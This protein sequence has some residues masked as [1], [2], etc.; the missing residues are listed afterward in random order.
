MD[1]TLAKY[2]ELLVA[3]KWAGYASLT[4][5]DY[6]KGE[7]PG[8]FVILR[9]DVDKLPCNSLQVARIE[10]ESGI[11]AVYYFRMEPCSWNEDIVREIASLGHEVGYHYENMD[12]CGGDVSSA[13]GDFKSNLEKMRAV[14]DI[15]TICMHGS[16]RSKYDNRD[17]WKY[18]SYRDLGIIGEPYLDTDF[19]EVLYLSDTGRRWDGFKVSVRDKIEVFQ[20]EWQ[21]KGWVFHTTDDIIKGL[22]SCKLPDKM[23]LT[24][25]PQRWNEFGGRYIKELLLQKA[26]NAVKFFMVKH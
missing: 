11:K 22:K 20:A 1:F 7:R 13:Y 4:F 9:H 8:K 3:L 19:S 6:M 21:K 18:Y 25:H 16:P 17:L 14:A 24:T 23:M 5:S 10:S 26:K 12:K 2:K 15:S